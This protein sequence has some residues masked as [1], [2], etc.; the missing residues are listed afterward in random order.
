[1]KVNSNE[2]AEWLAETSGPQI[3]QAFVEYFSKRIP[4]GETTVDFM[5]YILK[6]CA[7]HFQVEIE[8]LTAKSRK[9]PALIYRQMTMWAMRNNRNFVSLEDIGKRFKKDH[10]TVLHAIKAVESYAETN[11]QVRQELQDLCDFLNENGW[12]EYNERL[13]KIEPLWIS[14][15][16]LLR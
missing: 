4:D 16:G 6:M 12:P 2:V 5:E 9:I 3:A 7:C 13:T 15:N 8:T 14:R 11:K 10:C 1:M